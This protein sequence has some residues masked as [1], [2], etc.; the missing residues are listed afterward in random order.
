MI[1]IENYLLQLIELLKD[2]YGHRLVYVGLQGS[3][4]REEATDD[5]DMD[6]M[7]VVEELSVSDLAQYRKIIGSLP[8]TEKSCGFIC[9]KEDLCNWNPLEIGHLLHSTKDYYGVLRDLVPEYTD[10]DVRNFVKLSVNNLY[11][12]IC[13]RYLHAAPEKNAAKLPGT[14]KSTFFILQNVYYLRTGRYVGTK[15]E[16]QPLLEGRDRSVLARCMGYAQGLQYDFEESF[17]LLFSW[18]KETVRNI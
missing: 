18:C 11:H 13:H 3:Y 4:L 9:G 6:I 8:Y 15:K 12:E 16:L 5:S 14:Y 10:L 17:D 1:D 2:S 7:V